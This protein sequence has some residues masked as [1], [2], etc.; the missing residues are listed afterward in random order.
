VIENSNPGSDKLGDCI[1]TQEM[2]DKVTDIRW[3]PDFSY[4]A[5]GYKDGYEFFY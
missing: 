1:D 2:S 3:S 5:V 4:A